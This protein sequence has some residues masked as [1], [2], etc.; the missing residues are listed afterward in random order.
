MSDSIAKR[1]PTRLVGFAAFIALSAPVVSALS[2]LLGCARGSGV[3]TG[4]AAEDPSSAPSDDDASA[5]SPA[6]TAVADATDGGSYGPAG[7]DSCAAS[8]DD[9]ASDG[10]AADADDSGFVATPSV[11]DLVI[12]EIMF[13]PSG[14]VPQAQWFEIYN[15]AP[16]PELLSGL[17]IVDG[18]GDAQVIASGVPVIVPPSTYVVLA[19][20]L[21]TA[22]SSGIPGGAIV[23]EYGAGLPFDQG[24]TLAPDD[25]GDLSLW[26][27]GVELVDVPYGPWGMAFYG[28]SI[29]LGILQY[30]DAD[31]PDNWCVAQLPWAPGSDDGTPGLA[32]DCL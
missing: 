1:R 14:P 19:R 30:L 17:T 2:L 18:W 27:G 22:T 13:D 21:A 10:G 3:P 20:D 31:Q 7:T 16:V 6:A 8:S 32:S 25:T 28:Q 15:L 4:F 26:S 12:T 23:Y 9:A 5:L 11:G 29:E 24:I